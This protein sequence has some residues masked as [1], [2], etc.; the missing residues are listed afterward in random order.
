MMIW[1]D[2]SH[3]QEQLQRD[4]VSKVVAYNQNIVNGMTAFIPVQEIL[5]DFSA[6][7]LADVADALD[8][9]ERTINVGC[10]GD[11]EEGEMHV[12]STTAWASRFIR[13]VLKQTQEKQHDCGN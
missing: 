4:H 11:V 3:V 13:H 10:V 2:A 12:E 8:C 9:Y 6:Q 7:D 1:A 5:S